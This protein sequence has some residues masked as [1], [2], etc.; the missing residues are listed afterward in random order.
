MIVIRKAEL[1][2]LDSL[3]PLFDAYRQ[4]YQQ[5]SDLEGARRFLLEH[6]Q[7]GASVVFLAFEEKRAVGF[8]QLYPQFSSVGMDRNWLLNDLYVDESARR[9]GL[10][11]QLL[12]TAR[13]WGR[14]TGA[15]WLLL[16]TGVDNYAAQ[17]LYEKAGWTKVEEIFYRVNTR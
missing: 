11:S 14:E 17:A 16:E 12:L 3:V 7:R 4:F 10:A 2:D 6:M 15:R 9:K 13:T 8:T 1:D 5:A